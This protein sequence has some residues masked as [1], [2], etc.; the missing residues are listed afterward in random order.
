METNDASR[1]RIFRQ[2]FK[3]IV[4]ETWTMGRDNGSPE[5]NDGFNVPTFNETEREHE[6]GSRSLKLVR[7]SLSKLTSSTWPP[8]SNLP[9]GKILN[10]RSNTSIDRIITRYRRYDG[11][12]K[13][14][15]FV[16]TK[17]KRNFIT[18]NY[19]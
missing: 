8:K 5:R 11:Q 12:T 2:S 7:I 18:V 1:L 6:G 13:I 9:L 10:S 14:L 15:L 16:V 19:F 3:T 4:D 17:S